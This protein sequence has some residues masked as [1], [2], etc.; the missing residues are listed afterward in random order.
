MDINFDKSKLA[1]TNFLSFN[2]FVSI[3]YIQLCDGM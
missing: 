1:N 3:K 2:S